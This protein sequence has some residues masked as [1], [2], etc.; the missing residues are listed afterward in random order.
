MA[1]G[2]YSIK[3]RYPYWKAHTG[4][5]YVTKSNNMLSSSHECGHLMGL[6]DRYKDQIIG[7]KKIS[8]PDPGY[9]LSIMGST[10]EQV[11]KKDIYN[12][13]GAVKAHQP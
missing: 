6:S 9:G 2:N 4:T 8:V 10:W 7:G 13:L 1:K 5:W 3:D 12:L 11:D